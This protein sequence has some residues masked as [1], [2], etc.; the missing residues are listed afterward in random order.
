MRFILM[1]IGNELKGDDGVGNRIARLFSHP[2]WLS[3]PCETVPENFAGVVERE[4]P[5]LLV[6]IDAADMG[7][8]PGGIRIIPQNK[9]GSDVQGTH[10]QPLR[11]L[12]SILGKHAVKII[13]IGVQPGNTGLGE[14]MSPQLQKMMDRLV[15]ILQKH[16][17]E[18]IRIL[19]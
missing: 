12:V 19:E 8:E 3:L 13:F 1:G 2:D 4:R 16:D 6:M 18:S 14:D 11:Q 10:G 9:L 7:I 5:E 15:R 17:W